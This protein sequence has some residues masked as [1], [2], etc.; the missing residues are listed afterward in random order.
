MVTPLPEAALW[1]LGIQLQGPTGYSQ[2]A[3]DAFSKP[4]ISGQNEV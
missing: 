4:P 2:I 1:T 3:S